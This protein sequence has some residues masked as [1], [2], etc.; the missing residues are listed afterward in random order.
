M[1]ESY[2]E[3]L[4]TR[5]GS[6]PCVAVRKDGGEASAGVRA[7]RVLSRENHAPW[8]EPRALRGADAV[9]IGGRRHRP[10]RYCEAWTDPA[11]SQTLRMYESTLHGNRE[12]PCSS[13]DQRDADRI[14][15]SKD[16]R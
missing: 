6:K 10:C 5:T 11:R 15:K 9:E 2:G 13:A 16:T 3:G 8:R 14:R 12:I 1:K 4:A 7:G